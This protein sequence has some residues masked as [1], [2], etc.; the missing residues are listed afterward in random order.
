MDFCHP[1]PVT[2]TLSSRAKSRDLAFPSNATAHELRSRPPSASFLSASSAANSLRSQ[3]LN[4]F[5]LFALWIF[6]T[7]NPA[8][9]ERSR[10]TPCPAGNIAGPCKTL[11]TARGHCSSPVAQRR[12]KKAPDVSPG[13]ASRRKSEC[14]SAAPRATDH[15]LNTSACDPRRC[16]TCLGLSMLPTTRN[17]QPT[18]GPS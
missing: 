13:S 7:P 9:P 3:R 17:S 4:S 11:T 2:P 10:G 16:Q 5:R 18:P 1:N 15:S 14:A 6:V 8:H 12:H